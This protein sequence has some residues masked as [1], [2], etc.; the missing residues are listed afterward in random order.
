M[1]NS[2][3][4]HTNQNQPKE[5]YILEDIQ[6]TLCSSYIKYASEKLAV[7]EANLIAQTALLL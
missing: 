7:R 4:S 3:F 1:I 2:P 6:Y 5:H